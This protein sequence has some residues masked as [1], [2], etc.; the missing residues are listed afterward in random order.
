MCL[1]QLRWCGAQAEGEVAGKRF[2]DLKLDNEFEKKLLEEVI[3]PDEVPSRDRKQ[4]SQVLIR[5][6][7]IL[8]SAI[9]STT[10]C[11]VVSNVERHQSSIETIPALFGS[12]LREAC[13]VSR[14][15]NDECQRQSSIGYQFTNDHLALL[16]RILLEL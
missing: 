11:M 2:K 5:H 9:L 15:Y 10:R 8:I 13:V 1:C 16:M 14:D 4:R 12:V 7:V 3:P 6:S